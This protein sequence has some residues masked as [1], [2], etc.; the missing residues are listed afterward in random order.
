[1]FGYEKPNK[2]QHATKLMLVISATAEAQA[3]MGST[4]L[5]LPRLAEFRTLKSKNLTSGLIIRQ[6]GCE[7]SQS[8]PGPAFNILERLAMDMAM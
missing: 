8:L 3:Y 1:M 7:Y 2:C 6:M 5:D 4:P